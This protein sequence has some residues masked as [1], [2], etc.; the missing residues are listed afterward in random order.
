[1]N[2]TQ[3]DES[4]EPLQPLYKIGSGM[5]VYNSYPKTETKTKAEDKIDLQLLAER[6]DRFEEILKSLVNFWQKREKE[7][8]LEQELASY[9]EYLYS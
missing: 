4:K 8:I 1:V 9:L 5:K 3:E 6:F 7:E 2:L